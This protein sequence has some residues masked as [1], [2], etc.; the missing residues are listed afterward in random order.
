VTGGAE[1][2]NI[3]LAKQFLSWGFRVDIV[4]GWDAPEP[5]LVVPSGARHIVLGASRT[6][7][8]LLP[9][10]HYLL[11][12]R[13]DA[14]IASMW[15]FTTACL[16]AHRLVGSRARIAVCEHSMLSVQYA[17]RGLLH[18]LMMNASI[19]LTYPLAHARVAV[20]GGVADDLALLSRI[21]RDRI[22]VVYN[23]MTLSMS[24]DGDASTAEAAWE[25]W[26]GPR[27]LTVGRLKAAKNHKLL[28]KAFKR[29]LNLQDA[30]LMILGTGELT[31]S[32]A[33]A[34][35]QEGIAEKVLMPGATIDPAPYYHSADLF[36][37]SS[38]REGFALVIV[39]ALA[40]GL[41]IVSTNCRSG[42]AEILADGRYGRLVP[43]GDETALAQAMVEA[44]TTHH[45][46]E[47]L[48][49]RAADF[50][51]PLVA[52]QYLNLL[53]PKSVV[54]APAAAEQ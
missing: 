46:R 1:V 31:G 45:D 26:T 40:S 42:P 44:L 51:P 18:R 36:V 41:P 10:A 34:A 24:A 29:L 27:I 13:P 39:E 53:F 5:R 48:K 25:G 30:R 16:L 52:E 50:A 7:K 12:N 2:V 19:A 35:R 43:V 49:R 17:D 38:D 33:D 11:S 47:A 54:A 23:P 14:V 8:V 15:P 20:S 4:N 22:A 6:R 32:V 37:L 28:I 9:F 21:A 3:T